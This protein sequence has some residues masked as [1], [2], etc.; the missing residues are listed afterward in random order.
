[1]EDCIH[2][3]TLTN[4]TAYIPW[5][6]CGKTLSSLWP[7]SGIWGCSANQLEELQQQHPTSVH[8]TA[9]YCIVLSFKLTSHCIHPVN[10]Q[11]WC[12]RVVTAVQEW[13]HH[14]GA[15]EAA[16]PTMMF[17]VQ[18]CRV[19]HVFLLQC[20]LLFS[21]HP[22]PLKAYLPIPIEYLQLYWTIPWTTYSLTHPIIR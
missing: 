5:G 19:K 4:S 6:P 8:M 1:M 17:S 18:L 3:T 22:I 10:E 16:W 12:C 7:S 9:T 21:L 20:P 14:R 11:F 15:V 2:K 13:H